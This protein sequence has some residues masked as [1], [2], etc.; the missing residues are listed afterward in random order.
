ML[1]LVNVYKEFRNE[2][3]TTPV[4]SDI[5]LSINPGEF[6][7]FIGPS[8]SGKTT[9]L[10]IIGGY[11]GVTSGKVL[12]NG[13]QISKPNVDRVMVFQG[14]EQ[15]LA[16]KTVKANIEFPLKIM[17]L[18]KKEINYRVNKFLAMVGLEDYKD[19]YPHQLSGGMKQ[20]VALARSMA[21]TPEYLLMDEPFAN[22]DAINRNLLQQELL[23]LWADI[24]ATILFVTHD[25][26]EA[27]ILAD[28][29]FVLSST[30][31]LSLSLD[32]N[33][34]R[35]RTPNMPDFAKM[36]EV[37]YAKLGDKSE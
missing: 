20:R 24:K 2:N 6:A 5:N 11:E 12:V 14:Y 33:L 4:L 37:I 9:L 32:N 8:G 30:G 17:K 36:W 23:S 15:L 28:K 31:K 35:P 10:R 34:P 21:L 26:E 29:I 27:I 18:D 22:L 13:Q 7:C 19:Y 3:T 1:E 25:I 16:W